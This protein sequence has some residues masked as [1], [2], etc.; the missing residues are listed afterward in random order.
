MV[1]K[2]GEYEGSSFVSLQDMASRIRLF[3]DTLV[4]KTTTLDVMGLH[5]FTYNA[6]KRLQSHIESP[7]RRG[8]TAHQVQV[9]A[10]FILDCPLV[11]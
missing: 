2:P 5:A 4:V 11:R 10:Y 6:Q 3:R 1:L 9:H 8:C 7:I